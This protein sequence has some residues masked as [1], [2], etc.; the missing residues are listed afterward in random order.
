MIIGDR[1]EPFQRLRELGAF[2]MELDAFG[3]SL[4]R[5]REALQTDQR[6]A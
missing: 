4:P 6:H 5:F 2:G 1:P 3:Q